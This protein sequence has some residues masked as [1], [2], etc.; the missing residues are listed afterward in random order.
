M[1]SKEKENL[2][3]LSVDELKVHG[4]DIEKQLFQIKFKRTSSP[5]ENPLQIR[6]ARRKAAMIKTLLRA[7]EAALPKTAAEVKK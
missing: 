3:T 1:K 6:T 7:K 2:K 4:R 5:L